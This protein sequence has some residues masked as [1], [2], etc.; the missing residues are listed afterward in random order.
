MRQCSRSLSASGA[1]DYVGC[2]LRGRRPAVRVYWSRQLSLVGR[3]VITDDHR[4]QVS[5]SGVQCEGADAAHQ[6]RLVQN[7]NRLTT[8]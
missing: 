6:A 5:F 2:D 7:R 4:D 3:S 1:Q 8:K